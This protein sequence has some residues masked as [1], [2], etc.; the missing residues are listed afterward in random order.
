MPDLPA[1]AAREMLATVPTVMRTIRCE[2]R[3][4]R[5]PGLSVPQFRALGFVHRHPGTALSDVAEHMGLSL[6][7]MSRLIDGLVQG[8]LIVRRHHLR[9]RRCMTLRLS[10]PGSVLLETALA[11][12]QAALAQRLAGLGKNELP[13]IV[14]ALQLLQP[15]FAQATVCGQHDAAVPCPT[16]QKQHDTSTRKRA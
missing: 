9:D 16:R 15:L 8:R 6:P 11:K 5:T 13:L 10:A 12:T 14:R 7:A 4:C 2:M 1:L 3:G